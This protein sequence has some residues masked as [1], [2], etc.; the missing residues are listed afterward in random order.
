MDLL[1]PPRE[2]VW[3]NFIAGRTM[4]FSLFFFSVLIFLFLFPTFLGCSELFVPWCWYTLNTGQLLQRSTSTYSWLRQSLLSLHQALSSP[5][6]A[7]SLQPCDHSPLNAIS[8]SSVSI[9]FQFLRLSDNDL[10]EIEGGFSLLEKGDFAA[11]WACVAINDS[12]Q[13]GAG[14]G[15][16]TKILFF[17]YFF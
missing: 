5:V 6:P 3:V 1:P 9:F 7:Q 13:T 14:T 17:F 8:S 12:Q 4:W 15:F 16:R 10:S 11:S 2:M